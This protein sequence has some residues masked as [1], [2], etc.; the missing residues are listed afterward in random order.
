MVAENKNN[1]SVTLTAFGKI[2]FRP[3]AAASAFG[4]PPSKQSSKVNSD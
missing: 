3:V 4:C 1:E 2:L